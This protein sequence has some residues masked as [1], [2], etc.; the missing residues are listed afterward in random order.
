MAEQQEYYLG[1][2]IGGTK[3]AVTL[4]KFS[5]T[6][7]TELTI[8]DKVKF[9]TNPDEKKLGKR[10]PQAVLEEFTMQ[11]EQL[12]LKH[13]AKAKRIGI[14]CGGP[15]DSAKGVIL[16][17]PNLPGW[18]EIHVTEYF[19]KKFG[20]ECVLQNDANACAVAEW[21][22]GAGKGTKNMVFLTFGTGLGAGLILDGKLYAG[23]SDMAGEIGHV[24]CEEDGP[25]GYGKAGSYEG[26]CSGGGI[27]QLGK[28]LGLPGNMTAKDIADGAY[29]GDAVCIEAYRISGEK[30]GKMLSVLIDVLN[31]EAIV[32][33][34]IFSRSS[35]LLLPYAQAVIER[36]TL[37]YSSEVC[38]I[39][40]VGLGELVGDYSAL[41]LAR[42]A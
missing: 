38:K 40:P 4:G 13:N 12:L 17:P 21:R 1:F 34:G 33:G 31:P 23:T 8:A 18:D 29:A 14:S 37:R 11:A 10:A 9:P 24:R 16:S 19:T 42:F 22:F 32:I 15:L 28:Q 41:A 3:C 36:E 7:E 27:A 5:G 30:L 25:V 39:L 6:E 20:A 2:D 26:F 35:D